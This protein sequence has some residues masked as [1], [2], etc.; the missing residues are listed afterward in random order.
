MT[1]VKALGI[2]SRWNRCLGLVIL[3][4]LGLF[5]R[6]IFVAHFCCKRSASAITFALA[7]VSEGTAVVW[8]AG[9]CERDAE[10][11]NSVRTEKSWQNVEAS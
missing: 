5:S 11:G 6:G 2:F 3:H 4:L 10:K 8:P 7:L 9:R 1:K